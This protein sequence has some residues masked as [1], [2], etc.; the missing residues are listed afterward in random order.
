MT[1]KAERIHNEYEVIAKIGLGNV[2]ARKIRGLEVTEAHNASHLRNVA[3][4]ALFAGEIY[5][6]SEQENKLVYAC[7]WLHD[8]VRSP[9]EDPNISDDRASAK[10]AIRILSDLNKNGTFITTPFEREAVASAIEHHGKAPGWLEWSE[11]DEPKRLQDKLWL[12][13]YVGDKMEANGVRVIARRSSFVAGDRLRSSKGDLREFGFQP[14][15]DEALVVAVE[16]MLRLTFINPEDQYPY[17]LIP[18]VHPLYEAQREFVNGALK[19]KGIS[20]EDMSQLLLTRKNSKG[21]NI[22]EARNIAAPNTT[23]EVAALLTKRSG[24]TN[25][26]IAQTSNDV[27]RSAAETIAYFSKN[28]SHDLDRLVE[29]WKPSGQAAKNWQS[30]LLEYNKGVWLSRQREQYRFRKL[31]E[32]YTP[33]DEGLMPLFMGSPYRVPDYAY[34]AWG[35][36]P[37]DEKTVVDLY[38]AEWALG[39]AGQLDLVSKASVEAELGD[40]PDLLRR[41]AAQEVARVLSAKKF[42]E[43]IRILD[44]GAGP[45]LSTLAIYEALPE[46]LRSTTEFIL[47]DPSSESKAVAEKVLKESNVRYRYMLGTDVDTLPTLSDGSFDV[48]VGVASVHHHSRIPFELYQRVLKPGGSAVF[49]DWHSSIWEHPYRVKQF[50][51]QFDWEMKDTGIS[52]WTSVYSQSATLPERLQNPGDL[53]ANDQIT[54]FWKAYVR[55]TKENGDVGTN[56]IWPLEGHRPVER[57]VA[58]MKKVGFD[59]EEPRQLLPDSRL[60]MIT[61]GQKSL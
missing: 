1:A 39:N 6:F 13:L 29:N 26:S 25:E 57:Y 30:A 50:L 33:H 28:Y 15:R 32:R 38:Q 44:I 4:L 10:E 59:V 40:Y 58:D 41:S 12:A 11:T 14:D 34:A 17:V 60:L 43:P 27:A 55:L 20:I 61:I 46:R 42:S 54:E 52:H 24:I 2:D 7:G 47:I 31:L 16:S 8:V 37:T 3:E 23:T 18:L 51:G 45:G 36:H 22:F 48:I 56:A 49:A 35:L 19:A 9:S 21:K 53:K 5:G